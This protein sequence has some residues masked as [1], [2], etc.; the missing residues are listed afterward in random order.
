MFTVMRGRK[1]M[2][3]TYRKWRKIA[4]PEI[5]RQMKGQTPIPGPY[6]LSLRLDRLSKAERD[7]TN[8]L[9]G[10]EDAI[11]ACCVVR[12]DSDCQSIYAEWSDRPSGKGACVWIEIESV[13]KKESEEAGVDVTILPFNG[14]KNDEF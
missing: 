2:S 3:P 9:K 12:D 7:L 13:G 11:V 14:M 4:E 8:Y 5:Y 1:I 10:P 6:K